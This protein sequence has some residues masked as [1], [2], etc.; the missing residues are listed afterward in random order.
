[1]GLIKGAKEIF[2]S[3]GALLEIR[4]NIDVP[5]SNDG[6]AMVDASRWFV[7]KEVADLLGENDEKGRTIVVVPAGLGVD[8]EGNRILNWTHQSLAEWL[9]ENGRKN[10]VVLWTPGNSYGARHDDGTWKFEQEIAGEMLKAG[11]FPGTLHVLPTPHTEGGSQQDEYV[12]TRYNA[13]A[14][15]E[16][17]TEIW[18]EG[19]TVLLA[20][21]LHMPRARLIF[22]RAFNEAGRT[23]DEVVAVRATFDVGDGRRSV[24]DLEKYYTSRR[25]YWWYELLGV[26]F[27]GLEIDKKLKWA[28]DAAIRWK[29]TRD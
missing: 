15:L 27:F 3:L 28:R 23:I 21:D 14:A 17:P 25:G 11:G 26:V 24:P 8:E 1:M 18:A 19:R 4:K 13:A 20:A 22:E 6:T 9:L 5:P 12:D 7:R 2:E 29:G 10:D 16:Q